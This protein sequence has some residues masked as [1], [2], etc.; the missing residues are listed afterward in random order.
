MPIK[1][2]IIED[3]EETLNGLSLLLGKSEILDVVGSFSIGESAIREIPSL[4]PNVALVD[5][6]LPGVSGIDVIKELKEL[7]PSIEMLVLTVHEDK[8]HLFAALK[9]GATGYLLKDSAPG[10]IIEAIEEAY[11]HGSPMS[12]RVARYII[13]YFYEIGS[14]AHKGASLLTE[15]ENEI[16]KGIADGL[17][18]KRLADRLF[19]SPHTV[20]THLKKIYDKLHVH[21]KVEAVMRA[22][23]DGVI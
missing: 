21:S 19:I 7:L 5:I 18:D 15:R 13:E 6:G 4:M 23:R 8:G 9:A 11:N 3:K 17:T 10:E 20:R 1:V 14:E 12:P 22:K 2:A 16:L